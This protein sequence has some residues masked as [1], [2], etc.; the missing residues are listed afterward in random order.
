MTVDTKSPPAATRQVDAAAADARRFNLLNTVFELRA[1]IALAVLIVI[2]GV[3]SDSFLTVPNLIT[4]TKHVAINA[5]L[6]L[7]M[8]LV[9]LKGGSTCPSGRSSACPASWPGSSSRVSRSEGRSRIRRCGWW[10]CA[11]SPSVR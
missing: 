5:V 1:F 4:M 10:W 2:F 9:V 7:G 11:A 3:L 8:L 6:A